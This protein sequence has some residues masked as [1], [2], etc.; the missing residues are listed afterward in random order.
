MSAEYLRGA[1]FV[2]YGVTFVVGIGIPIPVIDE[3]VAFWCGVPAEKIF[4]PVVDYSS[5]Y[6]E[7]KPDVLC[8]VSYAQLFSGSIEIGKQK[9]PAGSL[10][11]F[12]MARKI[13]ETL[14]NWISSGKFKLTNPVA[15]LPGKESGIKIKGFEIKEKHQ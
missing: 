5:S 6:P 7:R 4:A 12:F 10:S 13:A 1:S 3:K 9:I 11:S 8:E 2:G 15:K 14:K